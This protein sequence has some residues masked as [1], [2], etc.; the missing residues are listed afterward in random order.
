M[1]PNILLAQQHVWQVVIDAS[2]KRCRGFVSFFVNIC[3]DALGVIVTVVVI[4][5]FIV[6]I[7]V[8]VIVSVIVF[9]I[10][11]VLVFVIVAVFVCVIEVQRQRPLSPSLSMRAGRH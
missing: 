11:I 8:I 1:K 2:F 3:Q 7:S 4:V 9:V 6:I 5:T 10:V